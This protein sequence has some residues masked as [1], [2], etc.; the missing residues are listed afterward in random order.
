[1]PVVKFTKTL[2]DSIGFTTKGQQIYWDSETTGLGLVIGIK[3]KSFRL[4]LDVKDSSKQKGY[5][6]VKKTLGRYG[7]DLTLEQAKKMVSGFVDEN[8]KVIIGERLKMKSGGAQSKSDEPNDKI[9]VIKLLE[10]YYSSTKRK[11]GKDRKPQ[12]ATQSISLIKRHF[13]AWLDLTLP[14]ISRITPSVVLNKYRCNELEF[15]K[16]TTRNSSSILKSVLNFGSATYPTLLTNNPLQLLSNPYVNIMVAR[17]ARHECLMY[18]QTKGRNDFPTFYEG[19]QRF[20]FLVRS[21]LLFTLY[22][23]MRR[24]EVETLEWSSINM[25]H[26]ELLILDTKNRA[27]L[28]I[29]L[30]TQALNI[31]RFLADKH[32][33]S[34]FVF[35]TARGGGKNRTGHVQMN[36]K[37]LKAYTGLDITVHGLRRTFI[38]IGRNKIKR[39]KDTSMLTNHLDGSVEGVHYDEAVL[40]DMRETSQRIG[41]TIEQYMLKTKKTKHV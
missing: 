21:A 7:T 34:K 20:D 8:G 40:D 38:N 37:T 41:N 6:T 16:Q 23:G 11:D 25:D 24:D 35:P 29:P 26:A 22:T 12:T 10:L 15:G 30:N 9:T 32:F 28:H 5:R 3:T 1:M 27:D 17:N 33:D 18:D 36:S 13:A 19:V 14:E 39:E 31:L 2:I 4:Q